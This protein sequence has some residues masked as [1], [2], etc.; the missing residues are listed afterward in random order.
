MV[1]HLHLGDIFRDALTSSGAVAPSLSVT[2]RR[3]VNVTVILTWGTTK[4]N[5]CLI[6]VREGD[7]GSRRLRPA[8]NW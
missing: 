1:T 2:V 6:C 4:E 3:N 8:V 5:R 7:I